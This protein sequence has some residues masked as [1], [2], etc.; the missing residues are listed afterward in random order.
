A[1]A[2]DASGSASYE[3]PSAW[4]TAYNAR[5]TYTAN[6]DVDAWTLQLRVPGGI[7]HIWN[8]EILDQDGDIYTIGNMSY[9]GTLAAGQSA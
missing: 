5:V 1:P 9:N 3:I 4:N 6:E 7:Q 8:G 2:P